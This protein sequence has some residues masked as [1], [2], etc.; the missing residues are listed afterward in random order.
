VKLNF[1]WLLTVAFAAQASSF[2]KPTKPINPLKELFNGRPWEFMEEHF[3]IKPTKDFDRWIPIFQRSVATIAGMSASSSL[4]YLASIAFVPKKVG[5]IKFPAQNA[6]I[7]FG[8]PIA[9]LI[10]GIVS[11]RFSTYLMKEA[12]AHQTIE[13]FIQ[14]WDEN[15]TYT[16]AQF[17]ATF[18][19]LAHQYLVDPEN[20]SLRSSASEYLQIIQRAVYLQFPEKY[21]QKLKELDDRSTQTFFHAII[22][23]D[24]GHLLGGI[25]ELFKIFNQARQ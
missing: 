12:I 9:A 14:E 19:T 4:A 24:I 10:G 1:L 8:A 16:P 2:T 17:H 7:F 15:R 3:I 25:V 18:D 6:T 22:T 21:E 11:H 20:P 23:C 5:D 13:K